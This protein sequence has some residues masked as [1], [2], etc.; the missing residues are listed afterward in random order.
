M[1]CVFANTSFSFKMTVL[2]KDYMP[3]IASYMYVY[4]Y[5]CELPL[6]YELGD[7]W[8]KDEKEGRK[9]QTN[10]KAKQH[11]TPKAVTFAKKNELPRVG[12]EPMTLYTH[13][14]MYNVAIYSYDGY[15]TE[16][17]VGGETPAIYLEP[18]QQSLALRLVT[19]CV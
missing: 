6:F 13:L 17:C 5:M 7:V 19:Q 12:L 14:Y 15:C 9:K 3:T 16:W 18:C 11:S 10:N 4:M 1:L 8:M 2:Y